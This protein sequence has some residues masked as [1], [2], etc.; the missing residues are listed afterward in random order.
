[1]FEMANISTVFPILNGSVEPT[2]PSEY[3]YKAR[4]VLAVFWILFTVFGFTGSSLVI[5]SV[6]LSKKLRTVTNAFVVNLSVADF[7]TA[8]SYPWMAVAGLGVHQWPLESEIPCRIA[9][10]QFNTGFGASLYIL[11]AI[12]VNRWV[13]VTQS[14]DTYRWLY[15][16]KKLAAMIA[17]T[18]IIPC[19]LVSLPPAFQ[20][21][22]LG[23]DERTHTCSDVSNATYNL[24]MTL[25]LYPIPMVIIISSYTALYV[26][27]RRHFKQQKRRHAPMGKSSTIVDVELTSDKSFSADPTGASSGP[28][29]DSMSAKSLKAIKRQQM[30]ITKNLFLICLAFTVL[31]SPYFMSLAAPGSAGFTVYAAI[32][33]T[34]N[35]CVSPIIY[36]VN[37]PH[38]KVIFPL[39]L[40]C[41]YAEIPEPSDF[42][43]YFLSRKK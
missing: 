35:S 31:V 23:F 37:H 18:W 28:T 30:A 11:A 21:G 29:I 7:W 27:I 39:M 8:M 22:K 34:V 13:V 20:A 36:T 17:A 2:S 3:H 6:V 12:A 25:G 5:W 4:V 32:I 1:M 42:L 16:P 41:R 26:H 24:V 33:A 14:I 15:T 40:T 9:A 10:L 43:K 38:F 19:L